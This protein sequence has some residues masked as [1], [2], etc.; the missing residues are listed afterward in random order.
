MLARPA[1]LDPAFDRR[2]ALHASDPLLAFAYWVEAAA[3]RR[4]EGDVNAL[5]LLTDMRERALKLIVR[6]TGT[7]ENPMFPARS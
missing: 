5:S 1:L 4:T 6:R 2:Q 7:S 3:D